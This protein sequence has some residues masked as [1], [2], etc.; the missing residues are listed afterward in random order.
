M[1][2]EIDWEEPPRFRITLCV[3]EGLREE[4]RR[5]NAHYLLPTTFRSSNAHQSAYTFTI[6]HIAAGYSSGK[7]TP[8][9]S[10]L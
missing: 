10:S 2:L 1:R 5:P 3:R 4:R 9:T 8:M 7:M 6:C